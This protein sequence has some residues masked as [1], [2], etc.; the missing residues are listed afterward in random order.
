M[1]KIKF[2]VLTCLLS[3]SFVAAASGFMEV[4]K[5]IKVNG[6]VLIDKERASVGAEIATG[7]TISLPKKTDF[8]EIRF[9]N[10][11]LV[12]FTDAKVFVEQVTPKETF[13]KLMKGKLYAVVKN[14]SE[15]EKFNVKTQFAS[16]AV[17]GTKFFIEEQ[18]KKSYLYVHDGVVTAEKDK[19]IVEVRKDFDLTV[20]K[21]G[22][23]KAHKASK[24]MF[25]SSDAV[26][27]DM[28]LQP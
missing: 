24:N 13:F 8:V 19:S 18:S 6:E 7:M 16:F 26:F 28:G 9:Q 2:L 21:K 17:R 3:F 12:R 22:A 11:H 15:G 25:D 23:L 27:E 4:A 14:L 10:G 5:V 20:T 1:N